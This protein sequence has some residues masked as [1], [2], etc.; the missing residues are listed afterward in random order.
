MHTPINMK[1]QVDTDSMASDEV[2]RYSDTAELE[3]L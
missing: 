1:L 2:S 3:S